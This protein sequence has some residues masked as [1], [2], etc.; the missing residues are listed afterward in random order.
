MLDAS[1]RPMTEGDVERL[2]EL[3]REVETSPWSERNFRDSLQ[4]GHLAWVLEL[5]DVGIVAWAVMM[6]ALDEAELLIIGVSPSMQ[7][8]GLGRKLLNAALD[9]LAATDCARVFLEVRAS[10]LPAQGLYRST[11]FLEVGRRKGYYPIETGGR[12]DAVLMKLELSERH[13]AL[14]TEE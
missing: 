7:R 10:N 8:R 1:L 12:E 5:P 3:E 2:A 6:T 14:K 4:S 13:N 9:A 11:G